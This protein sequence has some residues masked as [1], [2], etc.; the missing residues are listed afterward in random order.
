[1]AG[2]YCKCECHKIMGSICSC[3]GPPCC[4]ESGVARSKLKPMPEQKPIDVGSFDSITLP[5]IKEPMPD[6]KDII[7]D[8]S[9]KEKKDDA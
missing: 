8:N 5:K 6:I 2:K 7:T 1:M 3:W 4:P 9:V